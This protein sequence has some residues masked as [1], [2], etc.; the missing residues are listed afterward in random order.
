M[1]IREY[2]RAGSVEEAL[3]AAKGKRNVG[4]GGGTWLR[5][6]DRAVATAIDLS[7]L[8]LDTIEETQDAF[9]IGAMVTL[10]AMEKHPGLHEATHGL[11]AASVSHIVGVQ[12]RNLATIGGSARRSWRKS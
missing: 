10:R 9:S 2:L 11:C 5:L 12:F 6:E 1:T 4:L 3:E 7:G 8:G